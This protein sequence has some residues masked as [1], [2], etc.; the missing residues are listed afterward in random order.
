MVQ[1]PEAGRHAR[2]SC[3]V[4]RH[5][6]DSENIITCHSISRPRTVVAS[7]SVGERGIAGSGALGRS[8]EL[9]GR[10]LICASRLGGWG[11]LS[12]GLFVGR[13]ANTEPVAVGVDER[14]LSGPRFLFD[15]HPKLAGDAVHV[16]DIEVDE[17]VRSGI[18]LV[19]R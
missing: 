14:D 1:S 8:R 19:L 17:A 13:L 10:L 11:S 12:G 18:A 15:C 4:Q 5:E 7:I 6:S 16:L 2:D 9:L 3:S